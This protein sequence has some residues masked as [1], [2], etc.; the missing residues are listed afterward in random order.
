MVGGRLAE[1]FSING[2][3]GFDVINPKNVP[4][5]VDVTALSV[6]LTLSPLVHVRTG[7]IEFVAGPRLGFW[8]SAFELKQAGGTGKASLSGSL[9]GL[10][11]GLFANV[12]NSLAVGGL[13]NFDIR[14]QGRVCIQDPG[15]T[16]VCGDVTGDAAKVVGIT[17]A[18]LF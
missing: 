2:E 16:E 5:G 12:S 14:T 11:L 6:D 1:M 17:G 3:I 7:A 18:A 9:F 13:L 15:A 10:N 4:A 8:A